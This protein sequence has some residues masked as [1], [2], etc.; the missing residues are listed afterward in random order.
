M[1]FPNTYSEYTA[2]VSQD[3]SKGPGKIIRLWRERKGVVR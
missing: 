2:P 3:S 1:P